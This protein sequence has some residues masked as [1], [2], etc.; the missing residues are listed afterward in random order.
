MGVRKK[1]IQSIEDAFKALL[2][3]SSDLKEIKAMI[4]KYGNSIHI[5]TWVAKEAGIKINCICC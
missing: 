1:I 4:E 3:I 5:H 2:S